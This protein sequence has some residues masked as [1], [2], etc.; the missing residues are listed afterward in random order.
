MRRKHGE[1]QVYTWAL[2]RLWPMTPS[3]HRSPAAPLA[4]SRST[5]RTSHLDTQPRRLP[6][7][8]GAVR[9]RY[10]TLILSRSAVDADALVSVQV[11]RVCASPSPSLIGT[12]SRS[13]ED[14]V[15]S[16]CASV[17]TR[18]GALMCLQRA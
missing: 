2:H 11:R 4:R 8:P 16:A 12:R 1:P 13:R 17:Y 7:T 6:G 3:L 10:E 15:T 18:Y 14:A 5:P 9:R